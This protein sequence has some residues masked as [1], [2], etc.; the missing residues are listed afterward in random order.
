M[1]RREP[2]EDAVSLSL[3]EDALQLIRR[4]ACVGRPVL[5]QVGQPP[6]TLA[7]VLA[8]RRLLDEAVLRELPQVER[9]ARLARRE[10]PCARGGSCL[11]E[12][13]EQLDELEPERVGESP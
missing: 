7:G 13:S 2:G 12:G 8:R 10:P 6:G 3:D 11:A 5:L 1:I 4:G 9:A